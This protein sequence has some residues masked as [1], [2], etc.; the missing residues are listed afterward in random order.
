MVYFVDEELLSNVHQLAV[1]D[2]SVQLVIEDLVAAEED[3]L[4]H[5][6]DDRVAR[7]ALLVQ[8]VQDLAA[9]LAL[10]LDFVHQAKQSREHLSIE[11]EL[12]LQSEDGERLVFQILPFHHQ[13]M[14]LVDRE[15]LLHSRTEGLD[16]DAVQHRGV[17]LLVHVVFTILFAL[18]L[19]SVSQVAGKTTVLR[20]N[21]RVALIKL[22]NLLV[23]PP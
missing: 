11:A 21:A 14:L 17:F 6:L 15:H 13:D 19:L 7:G 4:K 2:P 22:R 3:A 10:L 18:F 1:H 9:S 5:V 8:G 16:V 12:L 20:A 23:L